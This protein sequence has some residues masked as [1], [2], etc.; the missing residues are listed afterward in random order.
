MIA[1]LLHGEFH[2][3]ACLIV[4]AMCLALVIFFDGMAARILR[5]FHKARQRRRGSH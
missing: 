4:V 3:Q 2:W 5:R 1:C